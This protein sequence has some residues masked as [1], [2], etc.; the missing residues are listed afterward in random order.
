MYDTLEGVRRLVYSLT[1]SDLHQLG[2]LDALRLKLGALAEG[3]L[4]LELA[5]P[6]VP[7]TYPAAVE[8]AAYH[9]ITEAVANVVRHAR[10]RRCRVELTV[11]KDGLELSVI[12]DGIG[13][14]GTRQSIG[15]LSMRERAEEL[16]GRFS[17]SSRQDRKT[18]VRVW[19]LLPLVDMQAVL[20]GAR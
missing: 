12:D 20:E 13:L 9:I 3:E 2:L 17:V 16:G 7:R 4:A 11:R 15:L 14:A 5:F 19:V 18:G 8:S 6:A 10:A 1:P